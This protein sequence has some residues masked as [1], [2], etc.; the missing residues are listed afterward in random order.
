ME[1]YYGTILILAF[2]A[3][4]E[5][6][7]ERYKDRENIVKFLVLVSFVILVLQMGFRWETGTD[8]VP[9]YD[10]FENFRRENSWFN[11][12]NQMELGY[13]LFAYMTFFLTADYTFFLILHSFI[14][15]LF[16]FKA[17][18]YFSKYKVITILLIY[19]TLIGVLGSN[20]QLVAL[21]IGLVSLKYLYD[22][23]YIYYFGLVFLAYFFHT[24]S[25]LFLVYFFLNRKFD[26]KIIIFFLIVSLIIGYTSVPTLLFNIMGGINDAASNKAQIYLENSKEDLGK[27]S[28]SI[29]GLLKR[30]FLLFIFIKNRDKI[31]LGF[32][33]YNLFLNGYVVGIGMYFLFSKSLL[34]MISRGSLYFN[35][36]EPLLLGAQVIYFKDMQRKL[37]IYIVLVIFSIIIFKQSISAYPELFDPYISIFDKNNLRRNSF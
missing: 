35:I 16:L 32:P 28:L 3:F 2:F 21:A 4:F 24:T 33:K 34:V 25:L 6:D 11:Y 12:E 23:K 22:K 8:W 13:E 37:I 19:V 20:R 36:A 9:Y 31:L 10:H 18:N 29:V 7:L 1:L 26:V 15:Y 27:V 30:L 5:I 14:F 17:I